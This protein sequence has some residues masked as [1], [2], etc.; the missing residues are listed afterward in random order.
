[1][2]DN[3]DFSMGF[4]AEMNGH[5]TAEQIQALLDG[6]LSDGDF[7]DAQEHVVFCSRCHADLEAWQL[8]YAELGGLSELGPSPDF[9]ARV[10]EH[11]PAQ[12]AAAPWRQKVRA[13]IAARGRSARDHLSPERLQD[14][15][16]GLVPARRVAQIEAHLSGCKACRSDM[17]AWQ[18]LFEGLG[19]LQSMEPGEGFYERV[20]AQH[21]VLKLLEAWEPAAARTGAFARV[22]RLV[23]RTRKAW[24]VVAGL[25]VPPITIGSVLLGEVFSN[26]ALT[27]G[28]LAYFLS[29][30]VGELG[31]ALGSSLMDG[32]VESAAAFQAYAVVEF[33]SGSPLIALAGAVAFAALSA[34]AAWILY[35]NLFQTRRTEQSYVRASI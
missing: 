18:G 34:S 10:L 28:Y 5:L 33:L 12:E 20:M 30:K 7:A 4:P 9:A 8:L 26:P 22:K 2:L 31:S 27:P 24:A 25:A 14:Y 17:A 19:T 1:M 15:V 13:W 21:R 32:A 11:I 6:Q 23:P 3:D 35:A 29:W 16:E